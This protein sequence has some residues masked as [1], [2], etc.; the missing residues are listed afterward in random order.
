M[1][2]DAH[3]RNSAILL[4][5]EGARKAIFFAAMLVFARLLS[6]ADFGS[7]NSA[8]AIGA[9]YAVA[10]DFGLN[11]LTIR[12]YATRQD[13]LP[14]HVARVLLLRLALFVVGVGAVLLLGVASGAASAALLLTFAALGYSVLGMLTQFVGA[15]FRSGQRMQL[16]AAA[17]II[18]GTV[19]MTLLAILW[20]WVHGPLAAALI[21][22]ASAFLGCLVAFAIYR[23]RYAWQPVAWDPDYLRALTR[24]TLPFALS[25]IL[26]VAYQRVHLLLVERLAGA[27]QAG[28]FSAASQLLTGLILIPTALTG[29]A[30][31]MM[32]AASGSPERFRAVFRTTAQRVLIFTGLAA[33]A[34]FVAAPLIIHVLFGA[35]YGGS[36]SILRLLV[37]DLPLFSLSILIGPTLQAAHRPYR[38]VA[39][40]GAN[41][42]LAVGL[43]LLLIPRL[44]AAGAGLGTVLT[45]AIGL[46]L[47]C[48]LL[49]DLLRPSRSATPPEAA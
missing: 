7:L 18:E 45:E 42:A 43:D 30:F 14:R 9:I 41:L 19:L 44:G 15:V 26:A 25:A 21:L 13:E 3:H 4:V 49:R 29:A 46:V 33:A 23:R 8:L 12:D 32:A 20:A 39:Y 24:R 16:E 10:S 31:P 2:L 34:V 28:I 47:G 17:R 38:T 22:L 40:M 6:V 1:R 37:L 36:A 11:E 5:S 27:E 35:R 48:F